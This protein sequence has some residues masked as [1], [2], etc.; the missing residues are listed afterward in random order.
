MFF[1]ILAGRTPLSKKEMLDPA[2]LWPHVQ[3][4]YRRYIAQVMWDNMRLPVSSSGQ[5]R[6]Q[7]II[8]TT[9]NITG[10]LVAGG[11][12]PRL[13]QHRTHKSVLEIMLGVMSVCGV[14]A[15]VIGHQKDVVHW[16]PCTIA[17]VMVLLAGSKIVGHRSQLR[18]SSL[19]SDAAHK[20]HSPGMTPSG[21][22]PED[23]TDLNQDRTPMS[24]TSQLNRHEQKR[25]IPRK[26]LPKSS[27]TLHSTSLDECEM[28]HTIPRK[29][30]PTHHE[31]ESSYHL[32]PGDDPSGLNELNAD[33]I[34]EHAQIRLGWWR[35]GVFMGRSGPPDVRTHDSL[36][37][38]E[39][40]MQDEW[41]YGIDLMS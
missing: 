20:R 7:Y 1:R 9:P 32:I 31:D 11:Q 10:T 5:Y 26:P 19:S 15:W 12:M 8:V 2:K 41:R 29:P 6:A 36:I 37:V 35:N 21:M 3:M 25:A 24:R 30:V 16:N 28:T 27:Q 34:W 38:E 40:E 13:V 23:A 33:D 14:L 22:T 4:F 17:G 18:A 39:A